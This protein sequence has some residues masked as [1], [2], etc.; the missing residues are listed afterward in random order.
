MRSNKSIRSTVACAVFMLGAAASTGAM[1]TV[2]IEVP[3]SSILLQTYS[4]TTVTL[5]YTGSVCTSGRLA[6]DPSDTPDRNKL[7]WA[8][9]LAA[10]ASGQKMSFDYDFNADDC[11]IRAFAVVPTT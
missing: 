5:F 11:A 7:L 2:H 1:A 3:A 4:G 9:V 10:K 8:S 6:L